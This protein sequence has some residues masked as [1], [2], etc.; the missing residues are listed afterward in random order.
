MDMRHASQNKQMSD[1]VITKVPQAEEERY[2][3][4]SAESV[5]CSGDALSNNPLIEK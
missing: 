3:P 2:F 1:N 4:G 5:N